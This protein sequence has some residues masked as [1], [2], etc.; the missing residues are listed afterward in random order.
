MLV[1]NVSADIKLNKEK[2]TEFD[3]LLIPINVS[4]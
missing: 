1:G 2:A 3:N 4:Y